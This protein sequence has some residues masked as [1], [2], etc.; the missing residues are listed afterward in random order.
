MKLCN[1]GRQIILSMA[2]ICVFCV[3][4]CQNED[5][6]KDIKWE[7]LQVSLGGVV[8]S[9]EHNQILNKLGNE[10]WELVLD[11]NVGGCMI[12]KKPKR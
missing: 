10:G 11:R 2:F 4:G 7:Y 1:L 8:C 6:E 12:F 9:E 3:L 5:M